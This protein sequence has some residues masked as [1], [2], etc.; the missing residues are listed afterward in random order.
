M[1]LDPLKNHVAR[2]YKPFRVTMS[3]LS[4]DCR[5]VEIPSEVFFDLGSVYLW[6]NN[7]SADIMARDTKH[8]IKIVNEKRIQHKATAV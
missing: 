2:G 5:R 7:F 8:A 6:G 4:G 3:Y 1:F